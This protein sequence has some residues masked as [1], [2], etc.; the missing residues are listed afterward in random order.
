MK[1]EISLYIDNNLVEF[2]DTLSMPFTYQFKDLNNPTIVK[3]P[4]TKTIDIIGTPHNNN[5][6]GQIYDLTRE[7]IY[8]NGLMSGAFFNASKRTPFAI[9]KNNECIESGYM[10]LNT[11]TKQNKDIVYNVT[12]YGGIGNFFY[13]LIYNE[14][15][16]KLSLSDIVYN[17]KDENGNVLDEKNEMDFIINA[18]FVKNC[19]DK[20]GENNN[21]TIYDTITFIPS[22]NGLPENFDSDKVLIHTFNNDTF[23]TSTDNLF[24]NDNG[25]I[26]EPYEKYV[27]AK[28]PRKYTEWEIKDLR[29]YL[30]RPAIRL[31]SVINACANPVNNGG[32]QLVLD[33]DFFNDENPYYNDT[34]IALPLLSNRE[35]EE[36]SSVSTIA[37]LSNDLMI[38]TNG[39]DYEY[40]VPNNGFVITDNI[41][42]YTNVKGG[43]L[44]DVEVVFGI[45]FNSN[46]RLTEDK[47][48]LS[49]DI[50][51][52]TLDEKG[53]VSVEWETHKSAVNIQIVAE[54]ENGKVIACSDVISLS[55]TTTHN[56]YFSVNENNHRL[57]WDNYTPTIKGEH[58]KPTNGNFVSDDKLTY[59]W[60]NNDNTTNISLSLSNI[61]YN[62]KI[63]LK[64]K[65]QRAI[66]S[67]NTIYTTDGILRQ[68][69]LIP[70]SVQYRLA[71]GTFEVVFDSINVTRKES[72]NSVSSNT[73]I[74]KEKLLKT[75][76]SPADYLLS[77]T[78]LFNLFFVVDEMN[79]KVKILTMNNYFTGEVIDLDKNIDYSKQ[80]KIK[81][82]LFD[83]KFYQLKADG[84][85]YYLNKYKNE[86]SVEYGQKR[87]N[88]NYSFN[89][90]TEDLFEKN[91]YQNNITATDTSSYYH[92]FVDKQNKMVAPFQ[93]DGFTYTLYNNV[94]EF[95][96]KEMESATKAVIGGAKW[97]YSDGYD[98]MPKPC[99]FNL[100]GEEKT[101]SDVSATLLFY[102]GKKSLVDEN[103]KDLQYMITD[104][105]MQMYLLNNNT[106]CYLYTTT[107]KTEKI[108]VIAIPV[109]EMPM[110]SRYKMN[111][112]NVDYSLD[113]GLPKQI[114]IN[115]VTYKDNAT[116]YYKYWQNYYS[117]MLNINTKQVECYVN[118]RDF[119][120]N[121][122]SLRKFYFF[123]GGYWLLNK[124]ENYNINSYDTT[125]C[126]F[127]KIN[128]IDNFKNGGT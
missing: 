93:T 94:G 58:I 113:F 111:G 79:K 56:E 77:F 51:R 12:L 62:K 1:Q 14:D 103:G 36:N 60:K 46:D 23:N 10:Q 54:D 96:S 82:I 63:A 86:H 48:Y 18:D 73:L 32:Y 61:P 125:K 92:T 99:F 67:L 83:K 39:V 69:S 25:K 102:N 29:S 55:N 17:I 44:T 118:L 75:E 107:G 37:H 90:E 122:E 89:A 43:T 34:Y 31:R 2:S 101:L 22:N 21:G 27:L 100:N 128:N 7:Q 116:L 105:V 42:D 6:F 106:P 38:G 124:I 68:E 109:S 33:E 85:S 97:N 123:D 95:T 41:L 11:I 24:Y 66:D 84:E 104:D 3:N 74:T 115:D 5:I 9:Y 87:I 35:K 76:Y 30:Q 50:K 40:I 65:M 112:N 47:L 16:E 45:N 114:F 120:I 26:Y 110:F 108:E 57:H 64:M 19:F 70:S 91:I 71:K 126:I 88:T 49:A 81:P 59:Y 53:K 28:L 8:G 52:T 119:T 20:V 13:S 15:G 117:E 72:T 4:F 127:I 98:I 121:G 78:K 80:I